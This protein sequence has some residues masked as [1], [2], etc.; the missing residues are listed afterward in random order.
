LLVN[1]SK[2]F[3]GSLFIW[4]FSIYLDLSVIVVDTFV[5]AAQYRE[6][7]IPSYKL[8]GRNE[9]VYYDHREIQINR[10]SPNK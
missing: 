8:S 9:C 3:G 1:L 4:T 6:I 10:E 2:M 5:S 7:S